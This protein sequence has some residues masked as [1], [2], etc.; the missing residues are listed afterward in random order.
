M[1]A[2]RLTQCIA[3]N[4]WMYLHSF[5]KK[6]KHVCINSLCLADSTLNEWIPMH[7]SDTAEVT[8]QNV[9]FIKCDKVYCS[10]K[11]NCCEINI[12]MVSCGRRY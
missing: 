3:S 4:F 6:K 10:I 12:F 7:C 2:P 9:F 8:D 5:A 1:L 11:D